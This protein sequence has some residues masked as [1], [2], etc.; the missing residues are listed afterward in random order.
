MSLLL[1]RAVA[2]FVPALLAFAAIV[3]LRPE[4]RR[5]TAVFVA[6][7]WNATTLLPLNLAALR[8]GWWTFHAEG[9]M[10]AGVPL[11]LLLGWS[12]LWS[13]IPILLF[14]RVPFVGTVAALVTLDL[15]YMP[16]LQPLLVLGRWWLLGEAA[17]IAV[18]LIPGLALARWTED[19]RHVHARNVMLMFS[20]AAL[21]LLVIPLATLQ[22]TKHPVTELSSRSVSQQGVSAKQPSNRVTEQ[23]PNELFSVLVLQLL[24]LPALLGVT[25]VQEFSTRGNG[26]PLPYDP[27]K[28]LVTSGVYAYVRNPMQLSAT[29]LMLGVAVVMRNWWMLLAC[30]TTVVYSAGLAYWDELD[31]LQRFPGWLR[32]RNAVPLWLPRWRPYIERPATLY[33]AGGC[34]ICQ[35]VQRLMER[36]QPRG[37][38]IVPA[39]EHPTRD[40]TRITYAPGDGSPEV[41]GVVA[42]ARTLEH[43]HLA[44][45]YLAFAMRLPLISSIV[46]LVVDASGG[47]PRLVPR[48][49]ARSA[50]HSSP[51]C[52]TGL[53]SG[54][55]SV[56]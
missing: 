4:P 16:R 46:Q 55:R 33:I 32:Y 24:A 5:A 37:L 54:R 11:D 49:N 1:L 10:L 56:P 28:R 41:E 26:T 40:L 38:T 12:L 36:L 23:P 8:L 7:L 50:A 15:L 2:L 21:T 47:E 19:D 3:V 6:F 35:S 53:G 48:L 51:T 25:A 13:V 34:G 27:P 18:A 39:E 29:L 43:V 17:A 14:V 30:I 9:G 31:D 42:M 52:P 20:F 44:F 22:A 45:A